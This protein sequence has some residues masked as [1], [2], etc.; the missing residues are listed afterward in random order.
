M[1]VA[2]ITNIVIFLVFIA[3]LMVFSLSPAIWI[4][5]KLSSKFLFME[6]HSSK[7]TLLLTFTFS[8]IATFFIFIF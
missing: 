4:S 7:I 3:A 5:E 6:H 2:A 1:D 8:V